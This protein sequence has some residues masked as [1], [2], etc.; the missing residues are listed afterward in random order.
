MGL[1]GPLREKIRDEGLAVLNFRLEKTSKRIL[2]CYVVLFG[3]FSAEKDQAEPQE[4]SV[5][6]VDLVVLDYLCNVASKPE[7]SDLIPLYVDL[8][9]KSAE[10]C[11]LI[12]PRCH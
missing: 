6:Y 7:V 10:L 2:F 4:V 3:D 9:R 8:A 11:K 1:F 12:E 5:E